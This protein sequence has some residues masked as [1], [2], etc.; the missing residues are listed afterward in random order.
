MWVFVVGGQIFIVTLGGNGG[1]VIIGI[2]ASALARRANG[3]GVT[4]VTG[5]TS[6][7]SSLGGTNGRVVLISSNTVSIN[8]D[9]LH[10]PREPGSAHNLRTT[11]TINRDRV[12]FLCSG[13]FSRCNIVIDRLLVA[14]SRL[15]GPRDGERLMG[16]VSRLLRCSYLPVMGRGSSISIRRLLGNSGSYLSTDITIFADTGLLVL[17]ASASKLCSNGP[18]R[19]P[20]TGL[21]EHISLVSSNVQTVA[22]ST[23]TENA[24]KFVA[25]VGTT[26]VT[27]AGNIPIIVAGNGGPASVCGVLGN[28]PINACFGTIRG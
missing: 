1:E 11:T 4:L 17:L 5:L 10:L 8:A 23:N 2:N 9:E 6:I 25:G 13:L 18:T 21:V 7:L 27:M 15:R 16:A 22:N 12:V 14:C 3:T 19:G 20:G 24:N 26:R 28:R